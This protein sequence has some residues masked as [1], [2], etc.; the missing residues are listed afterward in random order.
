M[1]ALDGPALGGVTASLLVGTPALTFLG[2]IG[3]ALTVTLRR[4]GLLLS[5]LVV[6]LAVPVMIFSVSAASAAASGTV[7][8]LT[9]FLI[10]CA[11]G[12]A[13]LALAPI[14][15]AAALRGAAE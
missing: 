13:S 12:L 8:F 10:L 6:P 11:L 14:A 7:L 15:A 3:A 1:L 9:P 2:A 5:I 4:G